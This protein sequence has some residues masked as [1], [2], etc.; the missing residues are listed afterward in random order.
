MSR[1]LRLAINRLLIDKNATGDTRLFVDGF[2]SKALTIEQLAEH[3]KQGHAFTAE[4]SGHRRATNFVA[5][6]VVAVDIDHGMTV[7]QVLQH[8]LIVASAAFVCTTVSHT[9]AAPRLRVVFPTATTITD[10]QHQRAV[11]RSLAL[12]LG[13]DLSAT[14]PARIFF[15]NRG[16][17]VWLF[18][19][20]AM[21]PELQQE[22]IAQSMRQVMSRRNGGQNAATRSALRLDPNQLVTLE[23]GQVIAFAKI[24]GEARLHCPFHDD[25]RASAYVVTSKKGVHGIHCSTCVQTFWP[26][27]V[28]DEIDVS[29]FD[30]AV[31][32]AHAEHGENTGLAPLL[33]VDGRANVTIVNEGIGLSPMK[34]GLTFVKAPKGTGKTESLNAVLP[35][36][37][38]ALLIVHRRTLTRQSCRRL[39]LDCY[40]DL[41]RLDHDHLGICFDSLLRLPRDRD[42]DLVVIDE[43]EQ[44]LAHILAGTIGSG[45]R[46]V[47]FQKL[48]TM[49]RAARFVVVMDADIG[50]ASFTT[51]TRLMTGVI[52]DPAQGDLFKETS[53]QVRVLMNTSKPGTGKTID[54]YKSKAHLLAELVNALAEGKRI[55]VASTSKAFAAKISALVAQK[56]PN[57]LQLLLT[58]DTASGEQ[59]QTFLEAP[60]KEAL[61]Y[62]AIITSPAAGTGLDIT[63]PDR[64]VMV[65]LV[66]GFCEADIVTHWDFDQ[67]ISRVRQPGAVRVWISP[68]RL[69]YETHADVVRRDVLDG[70]L[71]AH[72]VMS[73]N[74]GGPAPTLDEDPLIEMATMVVAQQRW[75]KNRI[76][77][78]FK[79]HKQAQGFEIVEVE[80]SPDLKTEGGHMLRIASA[81]GDE[82]Y[83]RRILEARP[84]SRIGYLRVR[85]A[86]EAGATVS[87]DQWTSLERT[88]LEG[89]YRERV[90]ADLIERDQRGK[91]RGR[92]T[93]FEALTQMLPQAMGA[94][95]TRHSA[96]IHEREQELQFLRMLLEATP[97]IRNGAWDREA[98]FCGEDLEAFYQLVEG[99]KRVF[100]TQ[101]DTQCAATCVRSRCC[102]CAT[103]CA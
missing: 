83:A 73:D 99:H 65:D 77:Q 100:E 36:I 19:D 63:F 41:D 72:V 25:R 84:L 52:P 9:D 44:V 96:V 101:L 103:C 94:P 37:D 71:Q 29:S 14:D 95:L 61:K 28:L 55:F 82:E 11:A 102:S 2:E 20:R 66:V 70:I 53:R 10:P 79:A 58:A 32:R 12:R 81:L 13:G 59:Q 34:P 15:G 3:V 6:D 48:V 68:E 51:L 49:L 40:L 98:V 26:G 27:N 93:R 8:P 89:F 54:L 23:P 46:I 16:A 86:V 21:T 64:A 92:V 17:Q 39:G 18:P 78:N 67:H 75:S 88:K 62:G 30:A 50:W 5:T 74:A 87:Q 1:P 56:L 57:C 7:E 85:E 43:V 97:L 35:A 76:R 90:S 22:L 80:P 47:L 24:R 4:L 42:Y 38:S 60:A 31:I 45:E 91:F 33:G 69:Y